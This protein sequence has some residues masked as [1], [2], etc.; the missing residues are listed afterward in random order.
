MVLV[1]TEVRLKKF[2]YLDQVAHLQKALLEQVKKKR[3]TIT[4]SSW[5][6]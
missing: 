6:E 4:S 5:P 1:D 2:E 3:K